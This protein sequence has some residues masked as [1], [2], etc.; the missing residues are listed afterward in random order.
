M[1][2]N[3]LPTEAIL[4][5][6]NGL[7]RGDGTIA[8]GVG[9]P[10]AAGQTLFIG[11]D[12]SGDSFSTDSPLEANFFEEM[13]D[14][15]TIEE[16]EQGTLTHRFICDAQTAKALLTYTRGYIFLDTLGNFTRLLSNTIQWQKG[17]IAICTMVSEFINS[18][19]PPDLFGIEII[20]LNPKTEKHPRYNELTYGQ[21]FTVKKS[22]ES[23]INQDLD[24]NWDSQINKYQG[25]PLLTGQQGPPVPTTVRTQYNEARELLLKLR[26]GE[27]S[28]YMP[29][30]R[31]TWSKY[32]WRPTNLFNCGGYIEDPIKSGGL[33]YF[34]WSLDGEEDP[35]DDN[36]LIPIDFPAD[37]GG[38]WSNSWFTNLAIQNPVIFANGLS[39]LRLSDSV[40]YERTWL[41]LT[42]TWLGG[43]VGHWDNELFN[44]NFQPYQTADDANAISIK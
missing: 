17:G 3:V 2:S 35:G 7:N 38:L 39:W 4:F 37:T 40:D 12:S 23:F 33:P 43:P 5:P 14:S 36:T 30:F 21:K 25:S 8:G 6:P 9:T 22:A 26:R 24:K 44:K 16:A 13:P 41:K 20:E 28:F 19:T 42:S 29:G 1:P 34:F 18:N 10:T 15:P 32:Y 31:V 11:N 27:D